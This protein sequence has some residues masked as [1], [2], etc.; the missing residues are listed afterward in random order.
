MSVKFSLTVYT[1]SDVA[2]SVATVFLFPPLAF[3][4]SSSPSDG[5]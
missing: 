5:K 1:E 3:T 2:P 4:S